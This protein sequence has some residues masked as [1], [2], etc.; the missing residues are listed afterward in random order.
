MMIWSFLVANVYV[1]IALFA[2]LAAYLLRQRRVPKGLSLPPG[3]PG[4]PIIGNLFDLPKSLEW[5]TYKDWAQS[6]G[7]LVYVNV[8]GTPIAFVNSKELV[9]E[10][11]EKRSSIYSDRPQLPMLCDLMKFDWGIP[12]MPYGERWRKHRQILNK[13][14]LSSAHTF[15]RSGQSKYT[16]DLLQ[17]LLVSPGAFSAHIRHAAGALILESTYGIT[18]LP[19]N[20]PY[21]NLAEAAMA[22]IA[23]VA[24]PGAFLVD[25]L[26][27]LKYIPE[28]M[29]GAGFQKEAKAGRKMILDTAEVPFKA[30]KDMLSSGDAPSS[31]T[32]A[33]LN[34]L[35]VDSDAAPDQEQVIRNVAGNA[36]LGGTD[37]THCAMEIFIVAMILYPEVQSTAQK[38]LDKV[39]GLDRFPTFEDRQNLPYITALCK[40]VLRWH[41]VTP[42]A[43]PHR[44]SQDDVIGNY[45]LPAG[46]LVFGN[47]WELLHSETAYG[48]DPDKFRPERFLVEG[49]KDPEHA[50]GFG[51][52][53]CPARGIAQD[54]LFMFIASILHSF[55]ITPATGKGCPTED[56]FIPGLVSRPFPFECNI[57]P[58]SSSHEKLI[59]KSMVTR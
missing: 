5:K 12:T 16:K 10:L 22:I 6:Y 55:T 52:R 19:E 17:R 54:V 50:F 26:P 14:F 48:P 2:A 51:K 44:L 53:I 8:L 23:R 49:I 25:V 33:M 42:L 9:S 30:V 57:L 56:T 15:W 29:P 4:Y 37:T 1:V 46:T 43:F 41:L 47:A 3:P 39:V 21:L 40:E 24:Q 58:R 31:A 11:F 35:E 20:D 38:T 59:R 28:W 18:V 27:I 32:A 7:D 34:E 36:L 13:Q 45:F